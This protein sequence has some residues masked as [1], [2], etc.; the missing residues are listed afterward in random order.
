MPSYAF[1]EGYTT[2]LRTKKKRNVK[3]LKVLIHTSSDDEIVR[4][5]EYFNKSDGLS[6]RIRLMQT[7]MYD[8]GMRLI[9]VN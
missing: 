4:M 7:I 5:I 2:D 8:T 1:E 6:V 9:V 3:E